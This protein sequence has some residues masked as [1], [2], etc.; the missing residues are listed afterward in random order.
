[1]SPCLCTVDTFFSSQRNDY[2]I[3]AESSVCINSGPSLTRPCL[4]KIVFVQSSAYAK[5]VAAGLRC[6]RGCS[7]KDHFTPLIVSEEVTTSSDTPLGVNL[8]IF[9]SILLWKSV[10]CLISDGFFIV[11]VQRR[12]SA[13]QQH[14][15]PMMMCFFCS[16]RFVSHSLLWC[17]P[18]VGATFVEPALP[19][20]I[21][22]WAAPF[23]RVVFA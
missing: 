3:S 1:M 14:R 22:L 5:N 23:L 9:V 10:Y 16:Q 7:R 12:R 15:F 8:M 20:N 19:T 13:D 17:L 4:A 6:R 21:P 2:R 11:N 18:T